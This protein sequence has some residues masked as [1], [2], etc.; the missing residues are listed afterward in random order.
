MYSIWLNTE[1]VHVTASGRVQLIVKLMSLFRKGKK[2][3]PGPV[4]SILGKVMQQ[5]ILETVLRHVKDK[6]VI[7]SSEHRFTKRKSCLTDLIAFY[8]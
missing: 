5:L 7:G 1:R 3:D 2:D 4:T 8:N 6:K